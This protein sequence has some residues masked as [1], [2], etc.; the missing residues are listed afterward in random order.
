MVRRGTGP[1]GFS[2]SSVRD[3]IDDLCARFER[4][5]SPDEQ[6]QIRIG[7][8][9]TRLDRVDEWMTDIL[10]CVDPGPYDFRCENA[11][12]AHEPGDA[13][14]ARAAQAVVR[15]IR[16]TLDGVPQVHPFP[17]YAPIW[18]RVAATTWTMSVAR[19]QIPSLAT[20]AGALCESMGVEASDLNE[21]VR[22]IRDRVDRSNATLV[23][24]MGSREDT[25]LRLRATYHSA[26]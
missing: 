15:E 9:F 6:W 16:A 13:D 17:C 20:A 12:G 3:D 4:W 23:Q 18:R 21:K 7:S 10:R 1:V 2:L 19:A 22:D 8:F 5:Q 25:L 24:L 14:Q 11:Y 26:P